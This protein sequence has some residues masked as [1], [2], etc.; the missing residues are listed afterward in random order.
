MLTLSNDL[1]RALAEKDTVEELWIEKLPKKLETLERIGEL[2]KL[3][4]LRFKKTPP[5]LPLAVW[6]LPALRELSVGKELE[7]VPDE[8]AAL[9]E[10]LE[11]L[12]LNDDSDGAERLV[13]LLAP[14]KAL[15]KLW[16]FD[17]W[18][19]PKAV[20]KLA[21]PLELTLHPKPGADPAAM[22]AVLAKAKGVVDLR[23]ANSAEKKEPDVSLKGIGALKQLRRLKL[24][25]VFHSLPDELGKLVNLVD[26]EIEHNEIQALPDGMRSLKKLERLA[27]QQA[28]LRA[29]P[30]WIGGWKALRVLELKDD[31]LKALPASLAKCP[32]ETLQVGWCKRLAA[33]PPGLE[34]VPELVVTGSPC[35]EAVLAIRP[36]QEQVDVL[37]VDGDALEV[38]ALER[39]QPRE[40]TLSLP[41]GVA[42]PAEVAR[43]RRLEK[44]GLMAPSLDDR[45][46]ELLAKVPT[47]RELTV[48]VD[49]P[50][51]PGLGE[52]RG[53]T[54][55]WVRGKV[56]VLPEALGQ[57]SEL[58]ELI[59]YESKVE[60]LPSSIGALSKLTR[61]ST[62]KCG[63]LR[64]LPDSLARCE[65]LTELRLDDTRFPA[66]PP[67]LAALKVK[68]ELG[69]NTPAWKPDPLYGVLAK[70]EHLYELELLEGA[71]LGPAMGKLQVRRLDLKRHPIAS[72]PLELAD[73]PR[74]LTIVCNYVD[75]TAGPGLQRLL[76]ALQARD[77]RWKAE[78]GRGYLV[79]K[80][81]AP[82]S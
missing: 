59:L 11:E 64:S 35:E 21:G 53:L 62:T 76:P 49:A 9:G 54:R 69:K 46:F 56:K 70:N 73:C 75:P 34:K 3:R 13:E 78:S 27:A 68:L 81:K 26:L 19:V 74:L 31:H 22:F 23:F 1:T 80:R 45:A 10:R 6:S 39:A 52:L 47:L 40:L 42:F 57:L 16:L 82:K 18:V 50:L 7:T 33:L 37:D 32:L 38:G 51:P 24:Y 48:T 5:A 43:L 79:I 55:L 8:A 60:T 4:K 15:K 20:R 58:E 65:R 14:A 41:K 63:G 36:A 66:P 17:A 28:G 71:P 25:G 67:V 61:L 29:L 72:F 12:V 30:D 2:T 77:K 44:L